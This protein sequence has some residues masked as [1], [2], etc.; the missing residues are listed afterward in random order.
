MTE[1][2]TAKVALEY[3]GESKAVRELGGVLVK[4]LNEVEVESLPGDLPH[5]ILVDISKL[6]DLSSTL[7]VKDLP[8]PAKVTMLTP[9]DELVVKVQPPRDVAAEL[10][11]PI[12][13]D[14]TKVEGVVKEEPVT[15]E[16]G[17]EDKDKK[18]KK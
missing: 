10:A 6:I 9:G 16:A 8:V 18:D 2:L 5:N 3:T 4:L 7:H 14:V 12:V 13:E 17:A 1:T 15:G 11:E